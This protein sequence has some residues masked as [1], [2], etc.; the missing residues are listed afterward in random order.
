MSRISKKALLHIGTYS[1]LL[2]AVISLS[3]VAYSEH[4]DCECCEDQYNDVVQQNPKLGGT[5]LCLSF[6]RFANLTDIINTEFVNNQSEIIKPSLIE[7]RQNWGIAPNVPW[8]YVTFWFNKEDVTNKEVLVHI[9]N[10]QNW[11]GDYYV[12][13]SLPHF[14]TRPYPPKE[15]C[16][17]G[18][19]FCSV[20]SYG[21]IACY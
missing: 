13:F 20:D 6:Y 16:G 3:I 12:P 4:R 21:A 9:P 7:L 18:F 2:I 15:V 11:S 1:L 10:W 14:D 5:S 17:E 8:E 19:S